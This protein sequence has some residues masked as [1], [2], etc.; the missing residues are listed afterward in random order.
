MNKYEKN[1]HDFILAMGQKI[2]RDDPTLLPMR[3]ALIKEEAEELIAAIESGDRVEL[4]DACIDLYYVAIG[5]NVEQGKELGGPIG[6]GAAHHSACP[7]HEN[8]QTVLFLLSSTKQLEFATMGARVDEFLAISAAIARS[9]IA[10]AMINAIPFDAVWDEIHR[11]N[12]AKVDGPVRDDG[13]IL[14][15]EGW[16]PPDVAGVLKGVWG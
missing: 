13:K 2:N 1:V 15:P 6:F 14:K 4:A 8:K 10:T 11:S 9:A 12:M 16:V 7:F 3:L 5:A